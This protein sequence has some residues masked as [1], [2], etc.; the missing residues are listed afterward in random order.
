M[1][2][3]N[4]RLALFVFFASLNIA[5]VTAQT[6]RQEAEQHFESVEWTAFRESEAVQELAGKNLAGGNE[7]FPLLSP[8]KG[9]ASAAVYP[10]FRNLGVLDYSSMDGALLEAARAVAL[11]IQQG[12]LNPSVC[13]VSRPWLSVLTNSRLAGLS[14]PVTVRFSASDDSE[15][16]EPV[17]QFAAETEDP[18]ISRIY[19]ATFIKENDS[20]VLWDFQFKGAAHGTGSVSN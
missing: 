18:S 16:A 6:L 1:S 5:S 13:T 17:L 15:P 9:S 4:P 2:A 10:S 14:K 19:S 20:W 7:T 8:A 12:A 3:V 11:S